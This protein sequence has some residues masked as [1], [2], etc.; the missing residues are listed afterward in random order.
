[1]GYD[2]FIMKIHT[3]CG[4]LHSWFFSLDKENDAF[5]YLGVARPTVAQ[6]LNSFS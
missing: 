5:I 6:N 3:I 1:M 4:R 2:I